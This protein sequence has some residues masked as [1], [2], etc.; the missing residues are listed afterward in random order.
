MDN[1]IAAATMLVLT[2]K[3]VATMPTIGLGRFANA[4][5]C[6]DVRSHEYARAVA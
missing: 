4:S 5:G 3:C 1:A 6:G 2:M